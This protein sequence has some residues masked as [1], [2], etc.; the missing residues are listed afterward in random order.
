MI[1]SLYLALRERVRAR[2]VRMTVFDCGSVF[3]GAYAKAL[4]DLSQ[5]DDV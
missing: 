4:K 5:G 1:R 2:L 3:D